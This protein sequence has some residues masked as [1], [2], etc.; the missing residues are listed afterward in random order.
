LASNAA[1]NPASNPASNLASNQA[2]PAAPSTY[3][4]NDVWRGFI[5]GV[6]VDLPLPRGVTP[7]MM[8]TVGVMLRYAIDGVLQLMAVRAAAK[9]ELRA[10]VTVI[11]VRDNNPLKFSPNV[12]AA[13]S[14]LLQ[15]PG[16]G[17]LGGPSA[18]REAVN[19]LQSHQ[20]GVMAGMRAALAGVLARF[21]P[22]LLE[23]RLTKLSVLDALL[24]MNRK[25]K[26]WELFLQ[27]YNAIRNEA[28]EDFHQLFGKAFIAAYE[29]QVERLERAQ[30]PP[31]NSPQR[32]F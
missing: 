22:S 19:D 17:F 1:S 6:G 16:R 30:K 15:P 13:L 27:N 26:L 7:E 2:T 28:E 25:A 9:S 8:R 31:A 32:Q 14:Q 23:D 24:P 18:V 29:A 20:I 3:T 12:D 5:E 4:A 11:Q 10:A 21:E